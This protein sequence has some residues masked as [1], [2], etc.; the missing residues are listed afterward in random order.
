MNEENGYLTAVE[1][2]ALLM[3][4]QDDPSYDNHLPHSPEAALAQ[5]LVEL[6]T[7]L[8]PDPYFARTLEQRL[9]ETDM[10]EIHPF[11]FWHALE[12]STRRLMQNR[13]LVIVA[14]AAAFLLLFFGV[15][16]LPGALRGPEP[17]SAA[18]VIE[19]ANASML[20]QADE[21]EIIYDR[22]SLNWKG[23]FDSEYGAVG[24][25]WQ[26][27][28]GERFRYQLTDTEGNLLYFLQRDREWLWQSI[29]TQP[30]GT[31]PVSQLYAQEVESEEVPEMPL[32]NSDLGVGWPTIQQRLLMQEE[33]CV[34]L[35]CLLGLTSAEL[36]ERATVEIVDN[37]DA[38]T[39]RV[40]ITVHEGP[41]DYT[42]TVIVDR[43][44]Y[45]VVE[46][47]DTVQGSVVATLS[48]EERQALDAEELPEDFFSQT[49]EDITVV[50]AAEGDPNTVD[51]VWIVSVSPKP[52]VELDEPTEFE[53]VVGYDLVSLP[54]AILQVNLA[55]PG[56]K[57]MGNG[58][59]LPIVRGKSVE[60]TNDEHEATVT[61]TI[62]PVSELWM[63]P[64]EMALWVRLSH[65]EGV[66]RHNVI[67]SEH[68]LE[69]SW[70]L[71]P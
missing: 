21:G 46:V 51:R 1:L 56:F 23:G 55:R 45:A 37:G 20:V 22:L 53:V 13:I 43:D 8:V 59:R 42:R 29:H 32:I 41:P 66:F 31:S 47:V 18:E 44:T 9:F 14:G 52:G 68:F 67:A 58:G 15:S 19:R 61:F 24:E 69:Y 3:R 63:E 62:N 7:E 4:L 64:G 40:V 6:A 10:C 17:V 16:F 39:Y 27:S 2:D 49:S 65:V 71:K 28:E 36:E 60:V 38:A 12:N 34:D 50:E 33:V 35:Y 57:D 48:H 5:E 25:L 70:M 30:L 26:S 11:S 54:E